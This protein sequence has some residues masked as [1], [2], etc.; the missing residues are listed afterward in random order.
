[1]DALKLNVVLAGKTMNHL[2]EVCK[3]L[4]TG[5]E[6]SGRRLIENLNLIVRVMN[7]I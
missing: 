5:D 7:A 4:W 3:F 1:M 6:D 2:Q